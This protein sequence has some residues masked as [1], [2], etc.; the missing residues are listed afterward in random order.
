MYSSSNFDPSLKYRY[1]LTHRW[2]EDEGNFINFVLLNPSTADESKDDPTIKR[3]L[4]FAKQW[5][6]DGMYVTNLFVFHLQLKIL[7]LDCAAGFENNILIKYTVFKQMLTKCFLLV[8][9][10]LKNRTVLFL[11]FNF[12][13]CL[14]S[15]PKIKNF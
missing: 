7:L 8:T 5:G 10:V 9:F 13:E 12:Y 15:V 1:S 2:G 6:Y 11:F 4:K 3:C 14:I